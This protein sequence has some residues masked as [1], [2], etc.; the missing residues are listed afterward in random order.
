MSVYRPAHP[1]WPGLFRR[2]RD[3]RRWGWLLV[4]VTA[5]IAGEAAESVVPAS[6]LLVPLVVGFAAA[7][8]GLVAGKVPPS[9]N[10]GSQ[11]VL[12]VM[13][14]A[15]L[16]PTA[17]LQTATAAVPLTIVTALTLVLSLAAAAL[18]AVVA[19]LDHPTALLGMIA[20][21]SAAA[22]ACA[23]DVRADARLVA[24]MQ[25]LRVAL[26]AATAP[27]LVGWL[28]AS[29]APSGGSPPVNPPAWRLVTGPH[30]GA[31]LVLV[32]VIAFAG[33]IAAG[34]L[35]LPSAALLGPMLLAATL[36]MT[37]TTAGFAPSGALRSALLTVI[38]LDVGLRFTRSALSR[39]GRLLPLAL[40]CSVVVSVA[41]AMLAW[42]LSRL[43]HIPL[44]DAYLATTPGGINAV[45]GTAAA[46]NANI[47]LISS[48]QSLRLFCMV[49]LAP[50]L[51]R[52]LTRQGRPEEQ[53]HGRSGR[54]PPT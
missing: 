19:R 14:G 42:P 20:G 54:R 45:I 24:V 15:S 35:R 22:V 23:E 50:L 13:I 43:V 18:L 38:G 1:P 44:T 34:R 5:C 12:G 21:G 36:T 46:S 31:G 3:R 40:A 32:V 7:I 49:L 41:C 25:Y 16:S 4:V 9:V 2:P 30:Q 39:M 29:P 37:G 10:R 17:L 6:H 33:T 53:A 11:A 8:S 48:V 47:P 27:V 26:I 51:I 52:L 28:L